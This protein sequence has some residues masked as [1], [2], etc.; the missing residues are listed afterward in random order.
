MMPGII[1]DWAMATSCRCWTNQATTVT[2]ATARNPAATTQPP[3]ATARMP[4]TVPNMLI[5]GN[6]RTPGIPG[7]VRSRYMRAEHG[8]AL[9]VMKRIKSAMDP[10]GILNPGKILDPPKMDSNLRFGEDYRAHA[11]TSSL[12][13]GREG[14]LAG[15][16]EQCNGQGVCRKFDGT[17]CPSFQATR[18]ETHST[19]GRA[20][21]LRAMISQPMG[22]LPS[23]DEDVHAALDL[24]LACKGCK[25][26]CPSGVDMAK[27]KFAFQAQYYSAH[28]RPLRDF[29]FGYFHTV[30]AWLAP[31]SGLA[32][33]VMQFPPSRRLIA[34]LAG[35]TTERPFPTYARRAAHV[36]KLAHTVRGPRVLFLRDAFTHYVEPKVE[37]DALD[38]LELAGLD[39]KVLSPPH[40]LLALGRLNEARMALK[41]R[42]FDFEAGFFFTILYCPV[43]CVFQYIAWGLSLVRSSDRHHLRSDE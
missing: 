23:L 24:C 26:E 18:E 30:S 41:P 1:W 22:G 14:G 36:P 20:N 12:A 9:D 42:G 3:Q 27:L 40:V 7:A 38:L 16:I 34:R 25:S 11:W 15:A 4:H 2:I 6:V 19:R 10:K 5:S 8:D 28:R 13:F 37:Q 29:L 35:I 21:L 33:A 43:R 17:M 31:F 39:V 32:N